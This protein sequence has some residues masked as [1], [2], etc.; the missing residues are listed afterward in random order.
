MESSKTKVKKKR[1]KR[2]KDEKSAI[3]QDAMEV[4][5]PDPAVTSSLNTAEQKTAEEI[6]RLK[7][8]VLVLCTRG[9]AARYRH[10]M[11]DL[12]QL[13]PHSKKESK[14]DVKR[15]FR[16]VADIAEIKSCSSAVLFECRKFKDLY[17]WMSKTPQGP[18]IKFIAQNSAR[19]NVDCLAMLSVECSTH[20]VR[21][22][23]E[24]ESSER[25]EASAF[26]RQKLRRPAA[27]PAHKGAPETGREM[28][29]VT[30]MTR[31]MHV[32]GI[33]DA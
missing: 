14:L 24:W 28:T 8:R 11:L 18:S 6:Q 15:D 16:I 29:G 2:H 21:I 26:V 33:C 25:V 27:L 17:V 30:Q 9:T 19:L 10:L 1:G 20:N 12:I 13:L 22:E 4:D 32:Q 7:E 23:I 31:G 5:A 3:A